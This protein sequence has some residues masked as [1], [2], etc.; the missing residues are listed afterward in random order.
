MESR[1]CP[2]SLLER[3]HGAVEAVDRY[4]RAERVH[5]ATGGVLY[6]AD[7]SLWPARWVDTV[8]LLSREVERADGEFERAKADYIRSQSRR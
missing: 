6:G 7:S 5:R 1:E 8:A 4:H 2:R 3:E